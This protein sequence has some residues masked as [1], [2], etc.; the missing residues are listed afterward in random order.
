MIMIIILKQ[1]HTICHRR[2]G[3]ISRLMLSSDPPKFRASLNNYGF[4]PVMFSSVRQSCYTKLK[5]FN[6]RKS[7]LVGTQNVQYK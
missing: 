7:L 2:C 3:G 4:P 1:K 6:S 5:S